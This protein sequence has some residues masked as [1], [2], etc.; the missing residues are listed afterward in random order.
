MSELTWNPMRQA[1][2]PAPTEDAPEPVWISAADPP[3]TYSE[4][5]TWYRCHQ[6]GWE[7]RVKGSHDKAPTHD[8]PFPLV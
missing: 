3:P 2:E 4:Q 6:C 7:A 1:F 8:C 5:I